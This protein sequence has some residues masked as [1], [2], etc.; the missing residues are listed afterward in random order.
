MNNILTKIKEGYKNGFFHIFISNVLNK[1]LLFCGGILLI[2]ILTKDEFGLYSYSQNILSL[3]LLIN[4]FGITEGLMQYGSKKEEK[5][6]KEKYVKYTL[7][8]GI[9]SNILLI[10]L[11]IIYSLYGKLKINEARNILL[12][13]AFFPITN[14]LFSIIQTKL[15]IE[16]ENKKY[17]KLSNI[18]TFLD[19]SGMLIGGYSFGLKGVIIGKYIGNI[20]SIYFSISELKD[21]FFKSKEIEELT[22][23]EKKYINKFSLIAMLNNSISQLLYVADIF[24]IGIIIGKTDV[25]ASYKTATLI[26]FALTFIPLSVMVY[27]YPYFS[28]NSSNIFWIKKKY[29]ELIKYFIVINGLISFFLVISSRIIILIVFGDKYLDSLNSFIILSIG[30]F[31]A[32][33][34]RIPSGNIINALGKIKFNL[35][36]AILSGT[37]NIILD[38]LLIKRYGSIGAAYATTIIFFISGLIGNIF[39]YK[40]LNKK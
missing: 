1:I 39:L 38:I 26:P 31:F 25:L 36:N 8:I 10:S 17:S 7:R 29:N 2:R 15:R 37:L 34:L 40:I 23:E 9:I 30:Y 16:L 12:M 24:L 20:L 28:K 33:T 18:N 13:M 19:M 5:K 4:G 3:F 21:I 14:T 35:Y 6:E 27:I 22:F 11:I 32:S